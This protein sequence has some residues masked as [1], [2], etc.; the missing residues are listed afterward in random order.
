MCHEKEGVKGMTVFVLV[1]LGLGRAGL[2]LASAD[3]SGSFVKLPKPFEY[4][5]RRCRE[6]SLSSG[7]LFPASV[8]KMMVYTVKE[9]NIAEKDVR[10]LGQEYFSIATTAKIRER[11]SEEDYWWLEDG[12]HVL[13]VDPCDGMINFSKVREEEASHGEDRIY[14][15]IEESRKIAEGYLRIQGLWPQDGYFR[16]AVDN[17]SGAEVMSAGFGRLIGGYKNWGAGSRI[18]VDIA[19]GGEVIGVLKAWPELQPYRVYPIKSPEE[20]LEDLRNGKSV[21]MDGWNGKVREITLR[22]YTSPRVKDYVQPVYYFDCN[23]PGGEFYGVVPAITKQYLEDGDRGSI[24]YIE[25]VRR[26]KTWIKCR[27][28]E[29]GAEYEITLGESSDYFESYMKKHPNTQEM[30]AMPCKQCGG[31]YA[32][33]AVKCQ[34]CGL[35]FEYQRKPVDFQDRCPKCGHSSIDEKRQAMRKSR[36]DDNRVEDNYVEQVLEDEE[37]NNGEVREKDGGALPIGF[38]LGGAGVV[39][40]VIAGLVVLGK[41]R[42][43]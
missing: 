41:K 27:N 43:T 28:P 25:E 8:E 13:C 36:T 3:K 15:S 31:L 19:L 5:G 26:R 6:I 21:L 2:T 7:A 30:P 40:V 17:T 16:R 22:Y 34:E 39:A 24:S 12:S 18:I 35:V 11:S 14:P 1:L 4:S 20:A 42:G 23:G 9:P 38:V 37:T 33:V 10:V 32:Y 29:C